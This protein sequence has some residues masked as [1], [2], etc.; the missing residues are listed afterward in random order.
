MKQFMKIPAGWLL[1]FGMMTAYLVFFGGHYVAGD[2]AQRLAWAKALLDNHS[3]D[4]SA[5]LPGVHHSLYGIG[6]TLVHIPFLL[7]ARAVQRLTGISCEG[8]V[9]MLLYVLNGALACVLI[10]KILTHSGLAPRVAM[11]RAGIVGLAS[12]WFPYTKLEYSESLVAT[13]ILGT[14]YFA[15][16]RPLVAGLLAGFAISLRIDSLLWVFI[17]LLI[18]PG[19]RSNKLRLLLG[20]IPGVLLTAWSYWVRTGTLHQY[21][22]GDAGFHNPIWVGAYGILFSAGKSIFLFSPLLLL[23]GMTWRK[24]YSQPATRRLAVWALALF[25]GQLIFYSMWWDWS[26]DDSWGARFMIASVLTLHIIVMAFADLRSRL[27]QLLIIAGLCIQL[28]AVLLG[29]HTSLMLNHIQKPTKVNV[30]MGDRS[31]ITIDDVRFH[32]RYSQVTA[33]WELLATKITKRQ[34][35]SPDAVRLGTT[36]SEGFSEPPLADWDIFWF[37]LDRR[38]RP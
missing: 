33:T 26:G 11:W 24:A 21:G 8:P 16:R 7:L 10:Q 6:H 5:Y 37:H 34:P 36:W 35:R 2:N 1:F 18:V 27:I 15:P 38:S 9:N 17:T 32:P 29:P 25:A 30:Y 4:I 22:A 12:V 31:P 23:I 14:W 19:N 28:P 13:T 3:N 20:M